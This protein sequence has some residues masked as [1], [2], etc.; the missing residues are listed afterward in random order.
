MFIAAMRIYAETSLASVF[1][2]V[3][4]ACFNGRHYE[5]PPNFSA[6]VHE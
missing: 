1:L 6:Q 2:F 4:W 3:Q 5:M